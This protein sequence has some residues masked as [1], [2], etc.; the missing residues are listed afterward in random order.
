ME[1]R[2]FSLRASS[3]KLKRGECEMNKTKVIKSIAKIIIDASEHGKDY[4]WMC[5]PGNF[6]DELCEELGVSDEEI[7]DTVLKTNEP[8]PIAMGKT[9][10]NSYKRILVEMHYPWDM[11]KDWTEEGCEA[12]I[13]AIDRT[14]AL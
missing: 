14:D 7:Y 13:G 5:K 8:D 9:E 6:L 11:I 3:V 12:E 1:R 10:P 4:S 2:M